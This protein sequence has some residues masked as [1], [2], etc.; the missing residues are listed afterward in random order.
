MNTFAKFFLGSAGGALLDVGI[1]SFARLLGSS[2]T[3]ACILGFCSAVTL[4]YVI[5]LR[6]TFRLDDKKIVS[7]RMVKFWAAA[8]F[9]LAVRLGIIKAY[10]SLTVDQSRFIDIA[11]L[12]VAIGASF[13]CSF[14]IS[15]IYVFIRK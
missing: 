10:E 1:A 2:L 12:F 5:H 13:L 7:S 3:I 9:T 11:I 4:T 6:W 14:V 15:K 8:L